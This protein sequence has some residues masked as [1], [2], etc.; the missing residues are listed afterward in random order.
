MTIK[1]KFSLVST[2]IG[3]LGD[4]TFRAV[5]TIKSADII[6]AEDTRVVK[7]LIS[8]LGIALK[9][10]CKIVSTHAEMEQ[11]RLTLLRERLLSGHHV[12]M[13]SD[14]GTP[15]ISD[16][17]HE[18]T[19]EA[20]KL[21]AKIEIIPGPCAAIAALT[22]SGLC[23]AR[24]AFLG[25]LPKKTSQKKRLVTNAAQAGMALVIYEAPLRVREL[26][27]ELYQFLGPKPVVVAR[28]ITK[29]YETFHRGVLGEGELLPPLVEK[30]ECVIVVETLGFKEDAE[31]DEDTIATFIDEHPELKTKDLAAKLSEQFGLHKAEAYQLVLT[32]RKH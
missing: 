3:N 17:G 21:N 16:P 2:P 12:A 28:E 25:F 18:L 26:L 19:K 15:L 27:D 24:F 14:A 6:L 4:I 32:I 9:E 23:T 30:G 8:H 22:G 11:K 10:D 20:V 13:M 1:G 7:S 5:H 29:I 31:I